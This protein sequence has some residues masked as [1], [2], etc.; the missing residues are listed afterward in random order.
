MATMKRG[1]T[2]VELAIVLVVIGIILGMAVKGKTL[3]D[4]ARVKADL[5]KI[6]KIEAAT[7]IYYTKTGEL[8]VYNPSFPDRT[9]IV[10]MGL[11][12][13]KDVNLEILH[14][15]HPTAGM[16]M[17]R[18]YI[19]GCREEPY[20]DDPATKGFIWNHKYNTTTYERFMAPFSIGC[21]TVGEQSPAPSPS[22]TAL[23][24]IHFFVCHV[25]VALDDMNVR[26]GTVRK[27]TDITYGV[28]LIDF[29]DCDS[30]RH[31]EERLTVYYKTF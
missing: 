13:E 1:F 29:S 16:I 5:A 25:E 15:N 12:T 20:P 4:A 24:P 3:V 21:L 30:L 7:A 19:T 22:P 10:D 27:G 18:I 2:I 28:E 8:P 9:E 26:T 17:N 23:G 11:I 31:V 14:M 6:Y